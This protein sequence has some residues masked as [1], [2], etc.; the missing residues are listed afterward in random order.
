M[1]TCD[2]LSYTT[3][4]DAEAVEIFK[5]KGQALEN[6]L[7]YAEAESLTAPNEPVISSGPVVARGIVES[8]R[9]GRIGQ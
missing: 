3:V 7:L 6:Q 8:I 1:R 5:L 9:R 2:G 4:Q